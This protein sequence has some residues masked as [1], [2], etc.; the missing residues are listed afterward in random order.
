M[1]GGLVRFKIEGLRLLGNSSPDGEISCLAAPEYDA[2]YG[3]LGTG[4]EL[5]LTNLEA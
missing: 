1:H 2:G 4:T 3:I 5:S